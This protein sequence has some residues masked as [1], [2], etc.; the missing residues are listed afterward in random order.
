M[1]T[2]FEE[3]VR[4][5]ME[6]SA[7]DLHVPADLA[8]RARRAHKRRRQLMV[9]TAVASGTAVTAAAVILATGVVT[10]SGTG[11]VTNARTTAYVVKRVENALASANFVIQARGTGITTF[12]IHG[13]QVRNGIGGVIV[14][15]SYGNRD[16][17]VSFADGK[18]DW[19]TGTA[20]IGGRLT[21]ADVNY[22]NHT[23]DLWPAARARL[24]PC[25]T[26]A[27]LVLA[28]PAVTMPD[29]PAFLQ[30]MLG[31]DA[32]T[33]T[34]HARIGGRETTV[35]SGSADVALSKGYGRTVRAKRVR[36][37]YALY[38]DP[39]TYLPVRE[40]GS[41]ETYGGAAGPTSN[42]FVT[43]VR[44]LHPTPA[45]TAMALVTIPAGF[46]QSSAG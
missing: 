41:L 38:V 20:L 31:C 11:G 3:L 6:W 9:S 37:R 35:I 5:S 45:N 36:V 4:D 15:W 30:A 16:R 10:R 12:R 34:G 14:S 18:P 46:H 29:W 39:A 40:Y 8:G 13:R 1:N 25:T 26:T 27:Q 21:G 19:A 24:K 28:G 23:Y 43:D 17:T 2:E 32:A 44:W 7:A 22:H 42:T 33:R